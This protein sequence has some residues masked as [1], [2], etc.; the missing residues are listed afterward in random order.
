M[1]D[2]IKNADRSILAGLSI[3]LAFVFFLAFNTLINTAFP[4]NRLDLTEDK[5]FTLSDGTK[6]LLATIDEPIDVRLYYSR[7]F[8]EI[9]PDIARHSTRVA[10]LLGEYERLSNGN[11]RIEVFD[12]EPFS[13]EED[14]AVSDGL[15]GL[16]FDQTG[17]LVY[18][19]VAGT[20]ST[21]DKD[22]IG[23]L[24]PERGPFLEYDLTRLVHNLAN[25]DKARVSVLSDLPLQGTQFDNY[26]SWLIVDGMKQ[27]FDVQFVDRAAKELP[28]NTEVLVIAAVHTLNDSLTY[29]IDQFVLNGGR[30][31]AFVDPFAESM[32]LSGPQAGQLPPPGVGIA[33]MQPLMAAWGVEMPAGKFVANS[34]DAVRV[35]FPDPESGQQV[36]VDYVS[37]LTLV[38]DRFA[39]DD[40]VS[41]QLQRIVVSSAGAFLPIEGATTTLEPLI[42]TSKNSNLMS[43]FDIAQQ[44]NPIALIEKFKSEDKSYP[45]AVRI[46]G[47]IKTVFPDGP[48]AEVLDAADDAEAIKKAHLSESKVP[49]NAIL[50]GDADFLAD[51]N[52]AQVQEI[53]GQRL[54]I[55]NANNADFAINSLDNLRGSQALVGL[56]G[57]GL[58]VRPFEVIAEMRQ[59]ADDKFR[60]KEQELLA[61]IAEIEQNIEGLQREEQTTGVLLTSAQQDQIDNFRV[62][63]LESRRDLRGVQRS[64]RNDVETLESRVRVIN[65]WAVPVVI[66]IIALLLALVRRIRRARFYRA[67]LH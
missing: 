2:K 66:A 52:W 65:I 10:E 61:S 9:G 64:L 53:G 56:R 15:Q 38:G 47:D 20:N 28:E 31:L 60:A 12:P 49:F 19:G 27:F 3:G 34:D 22:A 23:Y 29:A 63:M 33:A 35:G 37:W 54:T 17:E 30:V 41:S 7:R 59:V 6:E 24:A 42:F 43:A 67:A 11:V 36:A 18:F 57:R 8:N 5:L 21:D 14:L 51:R 1:M 50:V 44:P 46:S 13:P 25:P 45:L 26:Q 4:A 39:Q 40:N 55:P 48:P 58:S 62:K 32:A 16:P